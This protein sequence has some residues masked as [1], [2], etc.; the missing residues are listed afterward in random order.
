MSS[1]GIRP[2]YPPLQLHELRDIKRRNRS[3]EVRTLLWEVW[4]LRQLVARFGDFL[5]ALG[6]NRQLSGKSR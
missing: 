3:P 2:K 4:R 5:D 6:R 1:K